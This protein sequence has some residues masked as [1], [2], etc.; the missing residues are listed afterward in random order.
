[1]KLQGLYFLLIHKISYNNSI[2]SEACMIPK[3][4]GILHVTK[5]HLRCFAHFPQINPQCCGQTWSLYLYYSIHIIVYIVVI[6]GLYM[7]NTVR[8]LSFIYFFFFFSCV[9]F[10]NFGFGA[11]SEIFVDQSTQ[12]CLWAPFVLVVKHNGPNNR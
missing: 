9:G 1:M 7:D 5:F 12:R 6:F 11:D 4:R 8:I 2:P 10:N 3:Y